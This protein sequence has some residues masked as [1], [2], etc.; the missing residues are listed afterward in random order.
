MRSAAHPRELAFQ[1]RTRTHFESSFLHDRGALAIYEDEIRRSGLLEHIRQKR[2]EYDELFGG[3]SNG[4]TPGGIGLAERTYLYAILR[5]VKPRVAVETG[6]AN[7]FSTAFALL[8]LAQNGGGELYSIDFPREIGQEPAPGA[9]YEG[10][11]RAGIPPE[12][13]PGWLIPEYLR[14]SWTLQLG[15]TQDELPP[16]LAK[17]G[18]I[19]SFMHDSEHSFECMWF[20]FT[21]AWPVLREGGVLISDDVNSTDAF[22]EFAR[23]EQREPTAT[24]RGMAFLVK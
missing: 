19:D 18:T 9:F 4:Y 14:E 8:A 7:G 16:L 3:G 2:R 23:K 24:G 1:R 22:P 21:Q 11:G 13:G 10:T 20:E 5:T 6:V 12:H 17:L 15:R